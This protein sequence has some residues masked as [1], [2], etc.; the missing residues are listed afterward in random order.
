MVANERLTSNIWYCLET[1]NATPYNQSTMLAEEWETV[2]IKQP[3]SVKLDWAAPDG[4]KRMNARTDR[5]PNA[6]ESTHSGEAKR[7]PSADGGTA[8]HHLELEATRSD[9]E[10]QSPD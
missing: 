8:E 3:V 1:I 6:L 5:L 2:T 10:T 7:W 4:L 9:Q